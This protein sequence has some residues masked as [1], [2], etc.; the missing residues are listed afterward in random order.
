M[1][2]RFRL[3]GSFLFFFLSILILSCLDSYL[4]SVD[5]LFYIVWVLW[6]ISLCML[7]NAKSV[8]TQIISSVSN[9]SVWYKDSFCPHTIK[10]QKTSILNNSVLYS[11]S[12]KTVLFQTIQF[13]M[14]KIIR[15]GI[16]HINYIIHNSLY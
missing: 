10:C 15:M 3:S 16:N 9:N 6:Y 8:S 11:F 12:V 4:T 14:C 2:S 1:V 5:S 7:F 13:S